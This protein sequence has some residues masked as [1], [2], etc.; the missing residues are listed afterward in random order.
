MAERDLGLEV[1]EI[2]LHRRVTVLL[3]DT[4]SFS[5]GQVYL[6]YDDVLVHEG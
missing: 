3:Q 6:F 4:S 5:H 2:Q 1:S